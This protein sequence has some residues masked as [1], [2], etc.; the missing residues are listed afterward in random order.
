MQSTDTAIKT[1]EALESSDKD[2]KVVWIKMSQ[3]L[4]ACVKYTG[5]KKESQQKK[6]KCQQT[7]MLKRTKWEL[8][9][10][11]YNNQNNQ[12]GRIEIIS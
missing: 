2:I 4:Q 12:S 6:S 5:R 7:N 9:S 11:K 3:Q 8:K 10:E 1:T